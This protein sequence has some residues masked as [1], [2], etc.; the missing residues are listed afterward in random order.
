WETLWSACCKR[1]TAQLDPTGTAKTSDYDH[2]GNVT[3][4]QVLHGT[5]VYQQTTTRFDARHRPVASTVWLAE[6]TSVDP[7]NVPIAGL[8]SV[9]KS[10]GLTTRWLYDEDLTDGVGLDSATGLSVPKL[11]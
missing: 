10:E 11:G 4:S 8:D 9:A 3:H 7:K 6:Q 2:Y 1:I 5:D